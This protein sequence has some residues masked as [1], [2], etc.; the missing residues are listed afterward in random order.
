MVTMAEVHTWVDAPAAVAHPYG[1]FSVAPPSTPSDSHWAVGVMWE[2]W[3]NQEPVLYT[4]PCINGQTPGPK[5][6]SECPYLHRVKPVTVYYGIKQT[7]GRTDDELAADV[8][9]A[10]EEYAV[11]MYF[12]DQLL[13]AEPPVAPIL[14]LST[15][16]IDALASAEAAI[17]QGSRAKGV[18][19]MGIGTA[20]ALGPHLVRTDTQL[21]TTAGTPVVAGSG[22]DT[23]NTGTIIGSGP[24]FVYASTVLTLDAMDLSV[25]DLYQLAERTYVVGWDTVV[26]GYTV[27]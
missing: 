7:G 8:M 15:P 17:A 6:F 24:V 4:D 10:G 16:L 5:V 11:E 13:A 21:Q 18:I 27:A 26:A 20:T 2:S 19:H 25:N 12:W 22:Y 9:A 14:T 23:D 1:L 3:F